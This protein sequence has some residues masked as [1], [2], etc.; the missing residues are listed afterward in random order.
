MEPS[1]DPEDAEVMCEGL[2]NASGVGVG[3][4]RPNSS[5]DGALDGGRF[6][7]DEFRLY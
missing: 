1:A 3:L 2:G 6:D 7:V 4:L 5:K